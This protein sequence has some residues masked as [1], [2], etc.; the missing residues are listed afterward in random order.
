MKEHDEVREFVIY[1]HLAKPPPLV[2]KGCHQPMHDI[3]S[4]SIREKCDGCGGTS[5]AGERAL[6]VPERRKVLTL[7]RDPGPFN[8]VIPP[9]A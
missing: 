8:P 2:C 1:R 6:P 9:A 4:Y 7:P 3:Y 5:L